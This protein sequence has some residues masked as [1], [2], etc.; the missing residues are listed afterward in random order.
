MLTWRRAPRLQLLPVARV[1]SAH[2][3]IH[4]CT[5]NRK[6]LLLALCTAHCA[7][8]Y[9]TMTTLPCLSS[10]PVHTARLSYRCKRLSFV[11]FYLSC[12]SCRW[13]AP[14]TNGRLV[15]SYH[16]YISQSTHCRVTDG[17]CAI[18]YFFERVWKCRLGPAST[19]CVYTYFD[20]H[21]CSSFYFASRR[22]GPLRIHP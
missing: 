11:L 22:L 16:W 18:T 9:A 21:G 14:E 20:V 6:R 4:T 7:T 13:I 12:R 2:I 3:H 15:C 8:P 1:V 5:R 17:W 19:Y 10:S